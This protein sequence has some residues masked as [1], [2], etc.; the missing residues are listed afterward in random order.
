MVFLLQIIHVSVF[1]TWVLTVF[2]LHAQTIACK[3]K[4]PDSD[5]I[6]MK[7]CEPSISALLLVFKTA[8]QLHSFLLF[9]LKNMGN[10]KCPKILVFFFFSLQK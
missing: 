5:E 1:H 7:L 9:E 2:C 10:S 8:Y 3:K 6:A 4:M